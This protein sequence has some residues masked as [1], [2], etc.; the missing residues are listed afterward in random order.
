MIPNKRLRNPKNIPELEEGLLEWY[1]PCYA[2]DDGVDAELLN[3]NYE[4]YMKYLDDEYKIDGYKWSY[5]NFR[6]EI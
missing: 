6:K 2:D 3:M 4:E 5:K 1:R